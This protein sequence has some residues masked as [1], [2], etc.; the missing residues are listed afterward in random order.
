M[1]DLEIGDYVVF[2]LHSIEFTDIFF[3]MNERTNVNIS[4]GMITHR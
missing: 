3:G 4:Q 1:D 2:V